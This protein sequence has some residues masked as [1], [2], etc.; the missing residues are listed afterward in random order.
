MRVCYT[1]CCFQAIAQKTAIMELLVF[2]WS[3]WDQW[4]MQGSRGR[5]NGGYPIIIVSQP[6]FWLLLP[7]RTHVFQKLGLISSRRV[8]DKIKTKSELIENSN[9]NY[10]V[11]FKKSRFYNRNNWRLTSKTKRDLLTRHLPINWEAAPWMRSIKRGSL[12]WH[13]VLCLSLRKDCSKL[14]F[15]L[16]WSLI[17]D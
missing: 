2:H 13:L 3:V 4:G 17:T 14:S 9:N 11:G 8:G 15:L 6:S 16:P 1:L 5:E 7:R 10:V 12:H